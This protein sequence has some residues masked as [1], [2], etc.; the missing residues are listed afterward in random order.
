[1][2]IHSNVLNCNLYEELL[3]IFEK[4]PFL[5]FSNQYHWNED[6][7]QG[8]LGTCLCADVNEHIKSLILKDIGHLLPSYKDIDML[9]YTWGKQS[10]INWH[11]DFPYLFG[12]TIYFNKDWNRRDGGILLWED[13]FE[14]KGHLPKPNSMVLN[15]KNYNHMVTPIHY[16]AV[17]PRYTI[18][19]F[20]KS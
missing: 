12:A 18:Q 5:Y 1:M 13:E 15:T 16:D 14:I 3:D 10:G 17:S 11:T 7:L 19:I 2:I 8:M 9:Y 20:G 6:L 4:N